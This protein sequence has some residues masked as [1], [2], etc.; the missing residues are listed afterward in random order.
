MIPGIA[1]VA[2]GRSKIRSVSIF[3]FL[4]GVAPGDHPALIVFL[5]VYKGARAEHSLWS[6]TPA[7]YTE[8]AHEIYQDNYFSSWNSILI[9]LFSFCLKDQIIFQEI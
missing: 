5:K 2:L 7:L 1:F 4:L 6:F 3:C 8:K 9:D